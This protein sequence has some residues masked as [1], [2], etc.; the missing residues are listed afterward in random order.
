MTTRD[1][2]WKDSQIFSPRPQ[3][4]SGYK[5]RPINPQ[6]RLLRLDSGVPIKAW[7]LGVNE[8]EVRVS[9]EKSAV[10]I[11]K[12]EAHVKYHLV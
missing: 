5:P 10:Q 12:M 7:K 2:E 4:T 3:P 11:E 1:A 6:Q 8:V 9:S